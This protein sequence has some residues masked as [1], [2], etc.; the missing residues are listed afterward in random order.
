MHGS[1]L[2]QCL[3]YSKSLLSNSFFYSIEK[4]RRGEGKGLIQNQSK[5]LAERRLCP[6]SSY[7][8]QDSFTTFLIAFEY[9]ISNY[10]LPV[11][12]NTESRSFLLGIRVRVIIAYFT[13]IFR[14]VII[15][16]VPLFMYF[17]SDYVSVLG[18]VC[19]SV[20]LY[21]CNMSWM[22]IHTERRGG[23]LHGYQSFLILTQLP[24]VLL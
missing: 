9:R 15:L 21:A 20:T 19:L 2:V 3:A 16:K 7:P 22:Y 11:S 4:V 18:Y 1:C 23:L 17:S 10:M 5:F 6:K 24:K 14:W 13:E 8:G 12:G